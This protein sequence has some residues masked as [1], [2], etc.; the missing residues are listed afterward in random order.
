MRTPQ[1]VRLSK[2]LAA[3]WLFVLAAVPGELAAQSTGEQAA[4]A[5]ADAAPGPANNI[6]EKPVQSG[7]RVTIGAGVALVPS[8][9]GSNDYVVLPAPAVRGSLSGYN[10][11]SRGA[12]LYVDVLRDHG[13]LNVEFGPVV[14]INFNR[15]NR[16]VD[17]RVRAL[18]KRKG[19]FEAGGF[20]GLSKTGVITSAY[21]T[22]GVRVAVRQDVSGIHR[23]YVVSPSIDYGTPLSEKI[24]VGVS[25]AAS[26]AGRGYAE[27]YF[28][29]DAAGAARSG[30]PIFANP[31]GGFKDFT[32]S[33]LGSYALS[34]D[35]RQGWALFATGSWG[36]LQGDFAASPVTR[37]AGN[38]TQFVG[39]I[40]VG[41][42]F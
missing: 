22:L 17:P 12:A 33:A 3:A 4:D 8:Y 23:S 39:A 41:Y 2:A 20:V 38:P 7:D 42:T 10:F 28:A 24:Y 31:R 5:S 9:E 16:I 21:D 18:G 36:R 26:F 27:S 29:V 15:T 13:S 40:G 6:G 32:L 30:L 1:M 34:G 25:A 19:A 35:L 14:A 37:I 11:F